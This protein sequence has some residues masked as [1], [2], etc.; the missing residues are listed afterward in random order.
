MYM[1]KNLS[2]AGFSLVAI[3]LFMGSCVSKRKYME[4]QTSA[5]ERYRTDSTEWANRSSTMQQN[6][7]SLEQ[8]NTSFQK[9]MDSLR[10]TSAEYQKRWDNFQTTYTTS[11]EQLHQQIHTAIDQYVEASNVQAHNGK[12][13]VNLPEKML[14]NAG[15]ST[16]STKGKQALDKLAEVLATNNNVEV[17]IIATAAYYN[18]GTTAMTGTTG[19]ETDRST[20]TDAPGVTSGTDTK[21]P[22]A[23]GA[24]KETATARANVGDSAYPGS[25]SVTDRTAQQD[26]NKKA[27]TKTK[28]T[29]KS[30]TAKKTKQ[31]DQSMTFKS[32]PKGSSKSKS[33]AS[34][35]PSWNL[36]V[37]RSTSIVRE[38]TQ[39]GLPHARIVL[40]GQDSKGI[41]TNEWASTNRGYQV[42]V[43]P[44]M[45]YNQMMQQGQG[46][47][48]GS[49]SM[50]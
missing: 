4:A 17:D 42:V 29:Q 10:T 20:K 9:Q 16:L 34:S 48:Q 40:T 35:A 2:L 45:D 14:F 39:N 23:T 26:P 5:A 18:D 6:I 37:A 11:T 30:S 43:S 22:K 33:T 1:K 49:T 32:T 25:G 12:V 28:S 7:T 31:G 21:D 38:L 19:S 44:K 8:K 36:N 13:Y 46:T 47:G 27:T 41:M 24:D 3:G 15:S 50:K